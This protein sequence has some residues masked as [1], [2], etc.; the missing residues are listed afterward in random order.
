MTK[1]AWRVNIHEPIIWAILDFYNELHLDKISGDSDV[2][3]VDP[4][5]RFE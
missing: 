5:V 4:E 1:S 2:G 3:L